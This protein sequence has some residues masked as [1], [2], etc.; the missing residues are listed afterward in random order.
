MTQAA[1]DAADEASAA[2]TVESATESLPAFDELGLS[3]E[4]LRAIENLGYTAPTPVQAGS[5]PVVLEGRDLLAAAQ[6]GT[7]KTAAFLLPTMN[8]LEHI[9]PPKPVRERGGRNRRRGAKKP[10]GNGRGPL[11]LVITPTREL[12]QQIDEVAS[13]IADVTGHVAVTVVGGVSYKPQTAALKYGCDILVA[14]PGRLVDLIEQG[15]C[16]L[17]EVK[18]LVLDEADRMLDMAFYP[19]SAAS[20]AR[21]RPSARR[22]CSRYARRG[23]RGRDHRPGERPGPRGDRARYID[24]RHRRPVCVPGVHRGQEQPAARVPQKGGPGAHYRLYAHQAPR[25]QLLPS[26]GA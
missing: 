20:C 6:T 9:A 17:D 4:M 24:R 25:R 1:F 18:V 13:K 5:I 21:R 3:D 12:A 7:G 26:L 11:M 15:A 23:G 2:E 8:N 16:H 22:C 10:E 14:T 19:P